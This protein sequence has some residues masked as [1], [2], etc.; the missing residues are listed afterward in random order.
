MDVNKALADEGFADYIVPPINCP[1]S[2]V[3]TAIVQPMHQ[4]ATRFA[5]TDTSRAPRIMAPAPQIPQMP[6]FPSMAPTH[7]DIGLLATASTHQLEFGP[8]S[9]MP[10]LILQVCLLN[11]FIAIVKLIQDPT[12]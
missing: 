7:Q 4:M 3:S 12:N 1:P 2:M 10:L 9:D 11:Y 6:F 8:E 5:N